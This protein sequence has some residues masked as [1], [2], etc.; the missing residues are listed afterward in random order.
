MD[1]QINFCEYNRQNPPRDRIYR[2]NGSGDYLFLLLKTPMKF[3][4][5]GRLNITGENACILYTPGTCQDYSAV[6]RFRNSYVHFSC[7]EDPAAPFRLPENR[8]FYPANPQEL[9]EYFSVLQ[10][11][12]L[13][14]RKFSQE[15]SYFLLCELFIAAAR[16]L[17]E[18]NAPSHGEQALFEDFSR[19]RLEMLRNYELSW[20][21]RQLC[22]RVNMEKSQFFSYYRQFFQTTPHADLLQVRLEKAKS[23]LTNQALPIREVA[24]QCGFC[25]LSHFSR[26]FKQECGVSPSRYADFLRQDPSFGDSLH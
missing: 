12:F 24:E 2:P 17:T 14:D 3:Y 13:S 6:H 18:E 4:F 23:L 10:E 5:D 11:E 16:G 7:T 15:K 19:L 26:Y 1:F 20:T 8:I 25:D 21:T 9:D 22:E